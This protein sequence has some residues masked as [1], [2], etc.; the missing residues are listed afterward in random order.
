[1]NHI[2]Q[3]F[4]A[5][6]SFPTKLTTWLALFY[7]ITLTSNSTAQASDWNQFRGPNGSGVAIDPAPPTLIDAQNPVWNTPI[8]Q[9]HSSPIIAGD[10]IVVTGQSGKQIETIALHAQSG[11]ILWRKDANVSQHDKVHEA[12]T[13]A[14]STPASDGKRIYVYF[15]SFGLICYDLEGQLVWKTPLPT[16][17]TLYGISTSPILFENK[18]FL[19]LDDDRNLPD[20]QLSRSKIM[21][22][23][24]SNGEML[25]ETPRPYNRSSWSTP[26]VWNHDQGNDLVVMGNG[27]IYGYNPQS[28]QEK[29]FFNGFTRETISVP[30]AGDGKLFA[31]ASMRGGG[32]DLKLDPEPFW[33]AALHFDSNGDQ[34]VSKDEIS[35]HFTIPLR[36]ELPV[37]HPGFGIPLPNKPQARKQ[38]QIQFFDW[39][40]KNKDGLWTKEEFV[41]DMKVGSGR[42]L[43]A[44]ILPGGNGDITQTH[45]AWE[46]RRGIPEI[47]SPVY[48]EK[49]IYLVRAGGLLSC[50]ETESGKLIYRE[51]LHASGQYAASPI[52]ANNHLYCVSQQGMIS[53]VKLGDTFEVTSQSDLEA[54]INATPAIDKQSL[55][56]RT[57]EAI[58]AFR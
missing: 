55:Y 15:G 4:L 35:T 30:I 39:R 32:G 41:A 19:V 50:V 48:H 47:P 12:N 51:R 43:L 9:G 5:M 29:W 33:K 23:N 3:P 46:L 54:T 25:W 58:L 21:A 49:R 38:R 1:M 56:I 22:F 44:A 17:K 26:M 2:L 45:R 52:I 42:P 53:V 37:E 7:A 36:P 28:G 57:K 31:S 8:P 40:D 24:K 14:S 11:T 20:S 27:R 10:L 34:Q 18:V 6:Q 13:L 16:P